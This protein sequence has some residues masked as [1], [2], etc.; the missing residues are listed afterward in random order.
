MIFQV[1]ILMWPL[2]DLPNERFVILTAFSSKFATIRN[3]RYEYLCQYS[4][5]IIITVFLITLESCNV[6]FLFRPCIWLQKMFRF[7]SISRTRRLVSFRLDTEFFGISSRLG[8][9]IFIVNLVSFRFKIFDCQFRFV[10]VQNSTSQ[11]SFRF[12]SV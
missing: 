7:G 12:V 6:Y 3:Y 9:K 8:S 4:H 1:D 10:S 2:W 11:I 5:I